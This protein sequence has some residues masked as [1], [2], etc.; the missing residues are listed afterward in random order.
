MLSAQVLHCF[1]LVIKNNCFIEPRILRE[2]KATQFAL[3]VFRLV[4][5]ASIKLNL[6][7]NNK[8]C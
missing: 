8:M 7:N 2:A 3:F 6:S 5:I 4:Y 1:D